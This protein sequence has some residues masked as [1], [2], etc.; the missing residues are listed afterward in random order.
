[1]ELENKHVVVTGA[2]SGIGRAMAQRF[3]AEGARVT[4][5]DLVDIDD[6]FAVR[7][8]VS[9][10]DEIKRLVEAA[11]DQHGA[12]DVFCSN[13]GIGGPAGGPHETD[14]DAWQLTWDVNVMAHVRAARA[15]LPEMLERGDGYLLT[16]ASAAGVLTQAGALA[17]SATKHAAVAIAEWLSIT[18]A[19]AGIKVS[20]L[21][22]QGVK[23][24][25]LDEALEQPVGAHALRTGGAFLEPDEVADAVVEGI[26]AERFYIL[27]HPEVA[28]YMA[29]KGADPERWLA[30]MRKLVRGTS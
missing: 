18:Y 12:I 30:G 21:C 13:A 2:A 4:R 5:S 15:V 1:M 11:R 17:Y 8:D 6:G 25:M 20:C 22:P 7:A 29:L 16:T 19:D 24:P 27:P 23:T 14:D 10:E 9:R 3:A 26:G 28:Q